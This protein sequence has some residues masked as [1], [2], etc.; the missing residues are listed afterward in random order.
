MC[1]DHWENEAHLLDYRIWNKPETQFDYVQ[2]IIIILIFYVFCFIFVKAFSQH[3]VIQ[4]SRLIQTI[5][6]TPKKTNSWTVF[7]VS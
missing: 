5:Q 7:W 3:Q 4:T 1:T 6:T 2:I